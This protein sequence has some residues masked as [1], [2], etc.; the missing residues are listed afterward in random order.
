M[1]FRHS[2]EQGV[3]YAYLRHVS[4][5]AV[6]PIDQEYVDDMRDAG[7]GHLGAH[8]RLQIRM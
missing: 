3:E 2:S 8:E 6:M 4:K 5:Y 7:R 1:C